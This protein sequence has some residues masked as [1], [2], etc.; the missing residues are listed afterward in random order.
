MV[1]IGYIPRHVVIGKQIGSIEIQ[2]QDICL[3]GRNKTGAC[4]FLFWK[5]YNHIQWVPSWTKYV[6]ASGTR[7]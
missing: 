4:Y 7:A 1:A 5:I 2:Q 3:S 6:A